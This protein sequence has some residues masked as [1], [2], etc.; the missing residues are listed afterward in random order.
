MSTTSDLCLLY[1]LASEGTVLNLVLSPDLHRFYDIRGNYENAWKPNTLI[2]LAEQRGKGIESGSEIESL[3]QSFTAS[4]SGSRRIDP[5]TVLV[6]SPKGRLYCGS[7]EK[8]TVSLR[9]TQRGN[10]ADLHVSKSFLSIEQMSWS[11]NGR[12]LCYS[13]SSKR[14][15]IMTITQIAGKLDPL[16]KTKAEI[17]MKNSINGP[18]LQ[19]MFHPDSSQL[20]IRTLSLLESSVT[21]SMEIYSAEWT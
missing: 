13:D 20:P 5:I 18:V 4:Q 21:L 9:N 15:S 1:Q 17:P 11:S 3:T 6:G 7:T 8:G 2:R 10:L 12:L 16:V 14:V 19:F